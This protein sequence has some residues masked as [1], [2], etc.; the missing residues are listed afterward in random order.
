MGLKVRLFA[1]LTIGLVAKSA[2]GFDFRL[3]R[4]P[5]SSSID[6]KVTGADLLSVLVTAVTLAFLVLANVVVL[7]RRRSFDR[8]LLDFARD[9]NV[10][11]TLKRDVI[12]ALLDERNRRF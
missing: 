7:I 6:L 1:L 12:F 10:P 4:G 9:P 2:L 11:D 8:E 5:R 3:V